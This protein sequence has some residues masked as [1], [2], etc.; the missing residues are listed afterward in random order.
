MELGLGLQRTHSIYIEHVWV[1]GRD[2][3]GEFSGKQ[4]IGHEEVWSSEKNYRIR[5]RTEGYCYHHHHNHSCLRSAN[6]ELHTCYLMSPW[7]QHF[8]R[9]TKKQLRSR[10]AEYH[11]QDHTTRKQQTQSVQVCLKMPA[12][13]H[14]H[15]REGDLQESMKTTEFQKEGQTAS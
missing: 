4:K 13:N 12:L 3:N 1:W 5:C 2:M 14:L 8:K 6:Q 7:Q 11:A 9:D 10:E 15:L